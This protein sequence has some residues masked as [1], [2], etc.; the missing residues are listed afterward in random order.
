MSEVAG[1][2]KK[3]YCI[4]YFF[5]VLFLIV[6]LLIYLYKYNFNLTF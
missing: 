5:I 4:L 1:A 2:G 3:G 6:S